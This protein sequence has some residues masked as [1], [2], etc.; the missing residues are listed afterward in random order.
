MAKEVNDF[1]RAT[2][3]TEDIGGEL[4]IVPAFVWRV[5]DFCRIEVGCFHQKFVMS[6]DTIDNHVP[7][8]GHC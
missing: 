4:L 6:F 5:S 2:E 1:L 7:V 3:S 8:V